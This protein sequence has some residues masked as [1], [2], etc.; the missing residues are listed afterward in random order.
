M[1]FVGAYMV[2]HPPIMLPEVGRGEEK[3]I[4][5]TVEAYREVARQI[6]ALQPETIVISSPHSIMYAD[7]FHISPGKSAYGDMSRFGAPEVA[8]TAEYD[9][10]LVL[11]ISRQAEEADFPAGTMGEKDPSLDHGTLIPLYYICQAY[12]GKRADFRIIRVGLSALPLPDQY[13][14]GQLI[15]CAVDSLDRRA[16]YVASGDL[17]HKMKKD[18]PYGFA[19]EGPEYDDRVMKDCGNGEFG[20]LLDY[21]EAFCEKA[22]ECGHRSFVMMAGAM[23]GLKVNA[24]KLSHEATFGVGYGVCSFELPETDKCYDNRRFLEIRAKRKGVDMISNDPYVR[25]AALSLEKYILSRQ[26]L[27]LKEA[28]EKLDIPEEMIGRKAG[29]F[30]SLHEKGELRGCIGTIL[31]TTGCVAEE[32]LQNA[33][34]ACSRDPRFDPVRAEELPLLEINVDVLGEPEDI[35]SPEKLDVKRYGVIV[36]SGVR[37]GLLLPDLDGV[38]SIEQQIDIARQKGGIGIHEKIR[39]QRFEVVRHV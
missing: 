12:E 35:D 28:S 14:M 3:K 24:K 23:D 13:R 33:I 6:A 15:R 27:S 11:E 2:P 17:S 38:D 31:P 20:A 4:S 8:F 29:A 32:I 16:V 36:S 30:V 22:A 25:L 9:E 37:R 39:L 21:D 18:G 26:K 10:E 19:K 34:S 7:Y 1:G 5:A